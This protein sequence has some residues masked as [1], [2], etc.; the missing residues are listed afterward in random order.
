MKDMTSTAEEI[1]GHGYL[2][3]AGPDWADV[4]APW[5][6]LTVGALTYRFQHR[7]AYAHSVAQTARDRTP[8]VVLIG[9]AVDVEHGTSDRHWI[10][11]YVASL[12]AE[13]GLD[14]VVRYVAYLGGRF[15][16]FVHDGDELT[17]IPDCHAT[18]SVYWSGS[19]R[20]F[21]ASSHV[22]LA[23]QAADAAVDE[24][25]HDLYDTLV[26]IR[27]SAG[28]KY[29]PGIATAYRSVRPLIPNCLLEADLASGR[30][31]HRRFYPFEELREMDVK[32]TY[33]R[34][35]ELFRAHLR[36]LSTFG[37]V[38]ISVTSGLD[39]RTTLAGGREFLPPNSFAFTFYRSTNPADAHA[40]D[41]YGGNQT[42]WNYQLPHRVIRWD[43]RIKSP[44]FDAIFTTTFPRLSQARTIAQAFYDGLP[45]DFFHFQSTIAETGTVFYKRREVTEISAQRLTHLWHGADVARVESLVAAFEEFIHYAD[46]RAD[47]LHGYD[48]HDLFYWEHRNSRWAANRYHEAD[49]AHRVLLPFNQR[50]LIE[51]MLSLP[52]K[53]RADRV[54]LHH[55]IDRFPPPAE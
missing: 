32:V 25:A 42:A 8:E 37:P 36:L 13:H 28:T 4:T 1:F 54:L 14:A 45:R 22:E 6:S 43:G 39:S 21:V 26:E 53:D 12:A 9:H 31:V 5:P 35:E 41:L 11:A 46:F 30:T 52:F 49:L 51:T 29:L 44:A 19:G 27:G 38:G 34:F 55:L 2:V 33:E 23:G 20:D 10:A 40:E 15:T 16:C 48:Y 47:N 24:H 7:T 17:V 50:S 18:Q 3:S